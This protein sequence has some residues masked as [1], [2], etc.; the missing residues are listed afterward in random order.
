ML[1]RLTPTPIHQEPA[2]SRRLEDTTQRRSRGLQVVPR[3]QRRVLLTR[4][5]RARPPQSH[6]TRDGLRLTP[7][8]FQLHSVPS[9]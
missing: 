8:M 3:R 4:S 9:G 6:T 5:N 7:D 1:Q 2:A